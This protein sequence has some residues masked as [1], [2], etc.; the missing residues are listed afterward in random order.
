[1]GVTIHFEGRLRSAADYDAVIDKGIALAKKLNSQVIQLD[2]PNKELQ[3]VKGDAVCDYYGPV[4]GIRFQPHEYSDPLILEFDSGNFIQE[5]CKTQ[6]AG[7]GTHVEIISFLKSVAPHFEMLKV[8]D[9][10][11]L[12]ETNDVENL[13]AKF[14]KNFALIEKA[15]QENPKLNGPYRLGDRIIDLM[16]QPE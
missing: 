5:F 7:L 13:D 3:R 1:M 9:E 16:N 2:C 6:F 15:R 11:Q 14:E 4:R 10:G 12:W 8:V